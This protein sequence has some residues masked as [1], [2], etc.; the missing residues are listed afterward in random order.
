MLIGDVN[1]LLGYPLWKDKRTE[2]ETLSIVSIVAAFLVAPANRHLLHDFSDTSNIYAHC[3]FYIQDG[4]LYKKNRLDVPCHGNLSYW[5]HDNNNDSSVPVLV[6]TNYRVQKEMVESG[7]YYMSCLFT[8]SYFAKNYIN[9]VD[10]DFKEFLDTYGTVVVC[11]TPQDVIMGTLTLTRYVGERAGWVPIINYLTSNGVP[12]DLAHLLAHAV[13]GSY[14][15]S[16]FYG[17][18]C[19]VKLPFL[20]LKVTVRGESGHDIYNPSCLSSASKLVEAYNTCCKKAYTTIMKPYC[21][22]G[23]TGGWSKYSTDN[24]VYGS[25][26]DTKL[27]D[28]TNQYADGETEGVN[29]TYSYEEV[30]RVFL[31]YYQD[32]IEPLLNKGE[33]K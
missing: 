9:P 5:F 25:Q 29:T 30:N 33:S 20:K 8:E 3:V 23:K 10:G 27:L 11:T 6:Q 16:G 28:M 26:L 21:L 1:E 24:R 31:M 2:K 18:D 19:E 15:K 17:R 14:E 13:R 22:V 12:F 4:K 7:Y 32:H